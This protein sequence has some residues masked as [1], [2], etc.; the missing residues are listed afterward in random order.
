MARSLPKYWASR[1][2][3][4]KA[5][6]ST[7]EPATTARAD[8]LSPPSTTPRIITRMPT[9]WKV[10]TNISGIRATLARASWAR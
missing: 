4:T 5:T 9:D 6:T 10:A 8:G 1:F 2:S 3:A 7:L